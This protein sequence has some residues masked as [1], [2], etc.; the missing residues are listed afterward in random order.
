ME[1]IVPRQATNDYHGSPIAR[2]VLVALT[3]V[4][5]G[6]SLVHIFAPDGGAQSIATIPLNEFTPNGAA[7]VILIFAY[8]GVSQLLA[9]IISALV[10]WR[11]KN[12]IPLMYLLLLVEYLMRLF[13]SLLKPIEI[14]GMAPGG[15]GNYVMVLLTVVMLYL[16]LRNSSTD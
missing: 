16:S 14:A 13:L 4:A 1:A 7:T 5:I 6:R 9:G 11:Y 8:W 3:V 12:L 15:V 10:L 2:W